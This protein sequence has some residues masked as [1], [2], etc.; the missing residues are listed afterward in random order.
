MITLITLITRKVNG[1]YKVRAVYKG[2]L[3]QVIPDIRQIYQRLNPTSAQDDAEHRYNQPTL[4]T[5]IALI[6]L[7]ALVTYIKIV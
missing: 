3:S 4:V 6:A 2:G 5:L 1:V 7:I